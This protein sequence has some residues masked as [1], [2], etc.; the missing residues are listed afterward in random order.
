M[1][2][3]FVE[4]LA[5][6]PDAEIDVAC[7]VEVP[8]GERAVADD[9]ADA[10]ARPDLAGEVPDLPDHPESDRLAALQIE[11]ARRDAF[12]GI[13]LVVVFRRRQVPDDAVRTA[14]HDVRAVEH[15]GLTLQDLG[16]GAPRLLSG[17]VDEIRC[18]PPEQERQTSQRDLHEFFCL[19]DPL[20]IFYKTSL[21]FVLDHLLY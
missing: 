20:D 19:L 12:S 9:G 1:P 16:R 10:P 8:A 15:L 18:R 13:L 5:E 7:L 21:L 6:F 4:P 11:S 14:G 3:G 2:P 17:V